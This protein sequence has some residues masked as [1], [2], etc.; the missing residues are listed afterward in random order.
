MDKLADLAGILGLYL[1][2]SWTDRGEWKTPGKSRGLWIGLLAVYLALT[3]AAWQGLRLPWP[4]GLMEKLAQTMPLL[5][6][7]AVS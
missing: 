6:G 1:A 5:A 7:R 4:S 2:F 3:A